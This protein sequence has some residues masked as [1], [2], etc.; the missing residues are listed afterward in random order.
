MTWSFPEVK[1]SPPDIDAPL[2][3]PTN[4]TFD[5]RIKIIAD[6][7]HRWIQKFDGR[8]IAEV[9]NFDCHPRAVRC[10]MCRC[11]VDQSDKNLIKVKNGYL[12]KNLTDRK[13]LSILN[14]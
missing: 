2:V 6:A 9:S 4:C 8:S 13:L 14:F 3:A 11:V 5:Q 10:F 1:R 7:D 12:K